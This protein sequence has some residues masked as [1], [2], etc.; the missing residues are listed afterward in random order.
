M[1]AYP[2]TPDCNL[3]PLQAAE[4]TARLHRELDGAKSQLSAAEYKQQR[5]QQA[6][7]V[8]QGDL[9][10]TQKQVKQLQQGL[11]E[12]QA[13]VQELKSKLAIQ[14]SSMLHSLWHFA[15]RYGNCVSRCGAQSFLKLAT[16]QSLLPFIATSQAC[17]SS[18][19]KVCMESACLAGEQ[20]RCVFPG[21]F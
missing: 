7:S 4:G 21:Q 10:Q 20:G 13:E 5:G 3:H 16:V 6:S 11:A 17:W 12:S 18:S 15:P 14:V 8:V 19:T 1:T 9:L 2:V